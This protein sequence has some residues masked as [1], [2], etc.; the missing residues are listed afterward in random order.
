MDKDIIE[1]TDNI[2]K[3][4]LLQ[5]RKLCKIALKKNIRKFEK[6]NAEF[7]IAGRWQLNRQIGDSL[8]ANS[9]SVPK[10][11]SEYEIANI[12]SQVKET[13]KLNP[14]YDAVRNAKIY[15]QKAKKG[16]RGYNI[17]KQK[18]NI[19]QKELSNLEKL[20]DMCNK[21]LFLDE[22]SDEFKEISNSVKN[23]IEKSGIIKAVLN[24]RESNKYKPGVPYRHFVINGRNIYIGKN[25]KQNDELSTKF[26][27]PWDLWFHVAAHAGS[28]LI[29]RCNKNSDWPKKEIVEK[30]AALSAWFSKAKHT[31]YV[32]VD[33]TE[34]RFV[35]KRKKAP[36]GEVIAERCK[37]V[38]V[39]PMPPKKI[40]D[41]NKIL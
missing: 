39:S 6:Q 18:L 9:K 15:Y 34:A 2:S 19:T 23:S 1:S 26:A 38:R 40:F 14:K 16:K 20:I 3:K 22:D 30:V 35:H 37:R 11:V 8:L 4:K 17:C 13:I 36:P 32:D 33:V 27:N 5:F 25:K 10:G 28:H 24:K 7:E 21:C 41:D 29:L 12:H 31:S